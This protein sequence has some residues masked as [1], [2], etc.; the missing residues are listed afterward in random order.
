MKTVLKIVLSLSLSLMVGDP[1]HYYIRAYM[2][3]AVQFRDGTLSGPGCRWIEVYTVGG[4][5][6]VPGAIS[7]ISGDRRAGL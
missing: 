7:H 1:S 4:G 5:T 2:M 6:L 3:H